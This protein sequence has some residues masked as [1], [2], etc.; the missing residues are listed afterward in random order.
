LDLHGINSVV[1]TI[2]YLNN[3]INPQH[4]PW[5]RNIQV[6]YN[7][8]KYSE[9]MKVGKMDRKMDEGKKSYISILL[10]PHNSELPESTLVFL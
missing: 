7:G 4:A 1:K 9:T 3:L 8:V 10:I 6:V 2:A 5:V